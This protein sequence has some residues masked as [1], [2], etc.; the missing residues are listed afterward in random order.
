MIQDSGY[1]IVKWNSLVHASDKEFASIFVKG[2]YEKPYQ[3]F[4]SVLEVYEWLKSVSMDELD[5][6]L[7]KG[8]SV[9]KELVMKYE[10]MQEENRRK[11]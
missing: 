1:C 8:M 10:G 11:L 3:M 2:V 9:N 4:E 7:L 6:S 5:V